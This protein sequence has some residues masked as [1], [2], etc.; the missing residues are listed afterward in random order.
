MIFCDFGHFEGIKARYRS[1][2]PDIVIEIEGHDPKHP[3][4][5][6]ASDLDS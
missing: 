5:L 4:S 2:L 1:A 6:L 3:A